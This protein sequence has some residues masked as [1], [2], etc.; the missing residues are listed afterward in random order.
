M[1]LFPRML[2]LGCGCLTTLTLGLAWRIDHVGAEERLH[3]ANIYPDGV[4]AVVVL[5]ARVSPDGR[6]SDTLRAR[7]EHAVRLFPRSGAQVLVFSGGVGTF[8]ASEASVARELAISLGAPAALCLVEEDSHSTAE[9]ARYT[10]DLLER[11]FGRRRL[12]VI[13]V[14][15]PYHLL[16][17]GMLFA[18]E[19]AEVGTSPVLDAPRHR[20]WDSRLGWTL[21]EVPATLK[22]FALGAAR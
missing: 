5:G 11:H 10:M 13:V 6:P 14:S 3:A 20:A 7:V 12:G 2:G 16:R 21:R 1:R 18:Q 4:S 15:D 19:G 8:G 9:N 22:D 17:A